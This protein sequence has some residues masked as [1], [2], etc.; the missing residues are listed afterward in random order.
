MCI[1]DSFYPESSSARATAALLLEVDPIALVRGK[2]SG[3][4]AFAL[5]QYV[6]CLLYTSRCV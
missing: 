3:P 4:D 5:G 2:K 1:R 6:N